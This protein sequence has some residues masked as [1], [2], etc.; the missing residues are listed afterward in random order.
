MKKIF[1]FALLI[2]AVL[3][4]AI[5]STAAV[6]I[7]VGPQ[8]VR[9][10]YFENIVTSFDLNITK[11]LPKLYRRYGNQGSDVIDLLMSLG[12]ERTDSVTTIRH[13]EENWI[14]QAFKVNAQTAGA[15]GAARNITLHPD[16]LDAQNRFYPRVND[17]VTFKNETTALIKTIDTSVPTAPVLSV[18]PF[19]VTK[20]I[21][22]VALGEVVT[23]TSNAFSEGSTQPTGRFSGVWA[24]VNYNQIIKESLG[25][26]GTQMTNETWVKTM[27]GKNIEGWFNKGLLDIDHRQKIN[28]QGVF[29]TQEL[30]TN[31]LITDTLNNNE[32][33]K[34]T[35]GLFP[36]LKRVAIPYPY[37]PGTLAVQD[38]NAI[39]RLMS[40][41]FS[42]RTVAALTGQDVDIELEDVLQE[43]FKFTQI[44]NTTETT[45]DKLFGDTPDGKAMAATIAFQY[46]TKAQ[47]VYC[48]KRLQALNDPQ[49]YGADG[50]NY[51]GRAIL[52]PLE[53]R[54]DP[55]SKNSI[56]SI[57]VV[58]K[59]MGANSRKAEVWD[60]G[61]AGGGPK[62]G[63][64]DRR[65]WYM[66]SEMATEFFGGN[67]FVDMF[68]Q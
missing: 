1:S 53:K 34:T 51:P 42:S 48:M 20:P 61:A 38:F 64:Q 57:G 63:A 7:A 19:D 27:D 60:Y 22:A 5:D 29:M 26:S 45:N 10:D 49:T 54:I 40:R 25:A 35:E 6:I 15:A 31:P 52:V 32:P 44:Q 59:A 43:S 21:P 62:L 56:P 68:V 9:A 17:V 8:A 13:F 50:Y 24:Y 28:M 58:F 23:I 55:K 67:Q 66:R 65:D 46:F 33:T 12:F 2:V 3:I 11:W 18:V 16:S 14:H 36:Y 47:R 4:S 37:T 39:E 41:Q 30:T